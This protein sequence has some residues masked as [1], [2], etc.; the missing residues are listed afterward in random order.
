MLP[1]PLA[2]A[3]VVAAPMCNGGTKQ[4]ALLNGKGGPVPAD[5]HDDCHKGC[6]AGSDRRKT[7]NQ[8]NGCC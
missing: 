2:Q 1:A 6:H 4:I 7:A 5:G 3:R 8:R